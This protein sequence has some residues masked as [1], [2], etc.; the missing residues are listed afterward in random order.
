MASHACPHCR[1]TD[2]ILDYVPERHVM[3]LFCRACGYTDDHTTRQQRIQLGLDPVT[4]K[5][6]SAR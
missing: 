5:I 4:G 6:A 2:T 1:S 3:A